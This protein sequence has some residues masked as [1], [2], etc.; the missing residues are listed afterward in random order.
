MLLELKR[1]VRV[2][3]RKL[4]TPQR[5]REWKRPEKITKEREDDC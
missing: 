1:R 4:G 2:T 5:K 3:G